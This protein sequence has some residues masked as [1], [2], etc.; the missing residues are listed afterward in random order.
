MAMSRRKS[1]RTSRWMKTRGRDHPGNLSDMRRASWSATLVAVVATAIAVAATVLSNVTASDAATCTSA[2]KAKATK[3]LTTFTRT[4]AANRRAYFRAHKSRKAREAFVKSQNAILKRLQLTARCQLRQPAPQQPPS[5]PPTPPPPPPLP[6]PPPPPTPSP[7]SPP[8]ATPGADATYAFGPEVTAT[9]Q[10]A[11]RDAFDLAARYFRSALG[12]EL[13][14]VRVWAHT[15]AEA[16]VATYAQTRPNTSLDEARALWIGRG[17]VAHAD[18]DRRIY[19]GPLWFANPNGKKIVAK[20]AFMVILQGAAGD[21]ALNSGL[22]DIPQAGPRWLSEGTGELAGHLA[23]ASAGLLDMSA[24]RKRWADAAAASATSLNALA[25][26]RGQYE[27][28][29][30]FDIFAIAADRLVGEAG[31]AKLLT[32]F[33]AIGRGIAWPEAFSATFGKSADAYYAEFEANRR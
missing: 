18:F 24:A 28:A 29:K 21:S 9:E 2:Q 26:L 22:D 33:D 14:Q 31:V 27:T 4:M 8:P 10:A 12:R 15:D 20:E 17:L 19:I 11:V 1:G 5:P 23:V 30:A 16:M 6:A 25:V 13:P 7:P 3:M 32:Y